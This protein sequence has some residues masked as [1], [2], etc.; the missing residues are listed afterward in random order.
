MSKG[1]K[2]RNRKTGGIVNFLTID[3]TGEGEIEFCFIAPDGDE[4]GWKYNSLAEFNEE[5]E[6]YKPDEPLIEGEKYRK[7]VRTWAD[8]NNDSELLYDKTKD[9]LYS[10]LGEDNTDTSVC[11][12]FD[13]IGVFKKL[14]H[15]E[16]YTITE[17]C[18]EKE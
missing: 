9:C 2:L 1:M 16:L 5:W 12:S 13:S 14:E 4:R 3:L 18:G 10:Q 15:R 6:D 7:A 11:I 8:A 17:L